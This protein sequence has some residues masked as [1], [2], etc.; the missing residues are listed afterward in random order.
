LDGGDPSHLLLH[1][2]C[3]WAGPFVHC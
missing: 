2:L 1:R 3:L